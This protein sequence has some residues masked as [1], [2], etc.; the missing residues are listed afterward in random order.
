MATSILAYLKQLGTSDSFL[1]QVLY[2]SISVQSL[3]SYSYANMS[4][5]HSMFTLNLFEKQKPAKK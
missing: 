4:S 3:T 5:V 2:R 1:V